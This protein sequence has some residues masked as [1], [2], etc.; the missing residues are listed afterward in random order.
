MQEDIALHQ[1]LAEVLKILPD[2]KAKMKTQKKI[3]QPNLDQA[4][5]LS[6][7]ET[8]INGVHQLSRLMRF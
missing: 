1:N 5:N 4:T 3:S 2:K 8:P 7:F 6:V